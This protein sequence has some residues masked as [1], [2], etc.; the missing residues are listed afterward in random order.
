[1][2]IGVL[3]CFFDCANDLEKVLEPWKTFDNFTISSVHCQFAEYKDEKVED[4]ETLKKS[5]EDN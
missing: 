2:K 3:G 4:T 5:I 1:M